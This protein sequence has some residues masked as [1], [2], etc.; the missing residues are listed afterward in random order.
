M[1]KETTMKDCVKIHLP[2][3][4]VHKMVLT[5]DKLT[6]EGVTQ[7][8]SLLG[9]VDNFEVSVEVPVSDSNKG[10]KQKTLILWGE[11]L[12]NC[13]ITVERY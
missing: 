9:Q 3:G 8:R 1:T 6:D 2:N 12:K 10:M 13:Y 11:L 7:L 4:E 5:T